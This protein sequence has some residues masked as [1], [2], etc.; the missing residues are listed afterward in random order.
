MRSAPLTFSASGRGW[1]NYERSA[2]RV[3]VGAAD[4]LAGWK[5]LD[6]LRALR[7]GWLE[8][9]GM[10]PD[11]VVVAHAREVLTRL[12]VDNRERPR[13]KLYPTPD[14]GI[15]AEWT[16]GDCGAA[17]IFE[18]NEDGLVAEATNVETGEERKALFAPGLVTADSTAALSGWLSVLR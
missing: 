5:R 4:T 12:L 10:T 8:G 15:Q 16:I 7:D 17:L 18:S 2:T 14:G 1:T 13:L 11:A 6:E 9:D 3:A